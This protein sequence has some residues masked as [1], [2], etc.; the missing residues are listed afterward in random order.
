[1]RTRG[2]WTLLDRERHIN[3]LE[4]IGAL[5]AV[6]VFTAA[7]KSISAWIYLDNITAVAYINHG[8]GTRSAELTRIS[9]ALTEW[10]ESRAI[11]IEAVYLQGRLNIV[12]DEESHVGPDAGD[13]RLSP[14]VFETI[15][16]IWPSEV[17]IFASRWNAQLTKFI[18]WQP[19]PQA[20][21]VN[22]FAINWKDLAGYVFPPFTQIFKC[23][24]KIRREKAEVDF[25]CPTWTGQ[26]WFPVLLELACDVPRMFHQEPS[27]LLSAIEETHPLLTSD[28]LHLA[29]WKLSG[30]NFVARDFRHQWSAFSLPETDRE[31][32]AHTTP[33]G[34]IGIIGVCEGVR[35][36]YRQL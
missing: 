4:L 18:S 30:D 31:L 22:A 5:I 19:Q 32:L 12:A 15:Q 28:G 34:E 11:D 2:S 33:R 35:I 14:A 16:A 3:E 21:M 24:E 27:L 8:G 1:M 20:M 13:W 9:A 23:L 29:A 26:P 6:Q 25:I 36:P 7:A 17:D 10:C